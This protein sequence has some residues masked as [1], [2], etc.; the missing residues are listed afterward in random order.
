MSRPHAESVIAQCM[1]DPDV[2]KAHMAYEAFGV[3]WRLTG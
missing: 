3:L 2:R 1:T